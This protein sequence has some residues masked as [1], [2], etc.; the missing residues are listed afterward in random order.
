MNDE[1]SICQ[2]PRRVLH[3]VNSMNHGGVETFLLSM[4]RCY[5]REQF[6]MDILYTGPSEG[7]YASQ[8]RALGAKLIPCKLGREQI[9]FIYRLYK[10]LRQGKY[11]AVNNHIGGL[12]G[13]AMLAA[14]LAGVPARVGSYHSSKPDLG[15]LR[16]A[17]LSMMYPLV[18]KTATDITTSSPAVSESYF[19][20]AKI[21]RDMIHPISYGVDSDLFA[22]KPDKTLELKQ[23]GFEQDN[24]IIGHIGNYRPH[25]NH[26]TLLKIAARVIEAIPKARFLLC[27][28]E[29]S[30][31]DISGSYKE[32][33]DREIVNLGLSEYVGQVSGLEDIR[34][35]FSAIDV[36]VLPSKHEGM[37]VSLIEAQA[38]GKPVVASRINGI[39]IATAPE[40]QENLF[41]ID[42][43][44][45]FSECLIKL[46]KD[47]ELRDNLGK[48][49]Q[50]FV[51]E[52]L[53]IR[54]AVGKYEKLYLRKNPNN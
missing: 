39:A 21:P 16:N 18:V 28:F 47:K 52:N 23:F 41:E 44:E 38:A 6:H 14:W 35:F 2:Q 12:G 7:K 5:D 22:E 1:T 15:F 43:I 37:P 46:L 33:I 26:K 4:L 3:I 24:V 40:M 51:R 34:E 13:G 30:N 54:I 17:Y 9:R 27:G 53:D 20:C 29:C 36:F 19:S 10:L 32:Q 42:D 25:K 8:V 11:D 45:P 49:G 50:Q 48:L 31:P